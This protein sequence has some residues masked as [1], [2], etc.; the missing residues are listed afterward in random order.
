MLPL[1]AT[2]LGLLSL[3]L[4]AAAPAGWRSGLLPLKQ[5]FMLLMA[6]GLL[7]ILGAILAAIALATSWNGLGWTR[8]ALMAALLVLG[9]LLASVPLR[10]RREHAPTINDITTDTEHPPEILAALPARQAEHAVSAAYGGPAV[11]AQQAGAFPDIAP[12]RLNLPPDR[13]FDLALGVAKAMAGWQI[14]ANDPAAGRFEACQASFLFG[15]VDDIVIRVTPSDGGSRV[16]I[17]SHSRQGRGDLGVNAA[18]V[19]KFLAALRQAA[20]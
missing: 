3:L 7:G 2:A 15:F 18:R 11:A 1:L 19:R 14:L 5:D 9:L 12:V 17:R 16:D 6:G 8:I 20:G 4:L 10:L 13:A